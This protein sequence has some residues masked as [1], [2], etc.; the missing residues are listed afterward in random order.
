M[1]L[2]LELGR[3]AGWQAAGTKD[4]GYTHLNV[5]NH[6]APQNGCQLVTVVFMVQPDLAIGWQGL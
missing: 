5:A 3:Q 4:W 2:W 6:V 1:E